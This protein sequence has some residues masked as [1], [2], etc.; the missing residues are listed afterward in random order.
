MQDSLTDQITSLKWMHHGESI[1]LNPDSHQ[2]AK[3][4]RD[5]KISVDHALQ[6]NHVSRVFVTDEA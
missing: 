3:I 1:T 6:E 5:A 2:G 4:A